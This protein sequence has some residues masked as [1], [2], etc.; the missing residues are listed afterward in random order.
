MEMRMRSAFIVAVSL[1]FSV[2]VP[3][4]HAEI[5]VPAAPGGI[6]LSF[7]GGYHQSDA[8]GVAA[9]GFAKVTPGMSVPPGIVHAESTLP[10]PGPL[11]GGLHTVHSGTLDEEASIDGGSFISADDGGYGGATMGYTLASPLGIV[12]RVELYSMGRFADESAATSGIFAMRG[13]DNRSAVFFFSVPVDHLNVDVEQSLSTK[14][15]GFRFKSDQRAGSL[16]FALSAEPFYIRYDQET[17]TNVIATDFPSG[18]FAT[19]NR[20]SDVS[21]DLFGAQLALEAALP[22]AAK[23]SLIGRGSAGVY[24]VSADGDFSTGAVQKNVN[25]LNEGVSDEGSRAGYR[26]GAEAGF[27]YTVNSS[28][29]LSLTTSVDYLSEVPTAVLP[30]FANDSAAHIGFDDLLDWRTG[31]RLTFATDGA[32]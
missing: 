15:I 29:W 8:S 11:V 26:L 14:E 16:A 12:S 28:T 7:E 1:C 31:V 2:A 25:T 13:I 20:R 21:A 24:N 4:A 10:Q 18:I 6:Y 19:A 27:R 32:P 9:Q 5:G 17:D 22:L 3:I 23:L 30:R